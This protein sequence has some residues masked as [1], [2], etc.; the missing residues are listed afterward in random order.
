MPPLGAHMSVAGGLHKGIESALAHGC[1]CLQI[2]TKS[3]S[4]WAGPKLSDA[5]IATFKEAWKTGGKSGPLVAHDAYLTNL[6]SPDP[7]LWEKS[8]RAF[9]EQILRA[10]LLGL[11]FLVMHPGAHMGSGES[12]GVS[13]VARGLDKAVEAAGSG[14]PMILL[15][16][17]AGQGTTLGW[18][19]E[20]LRDIIGLSSHGRG[21]GICL[22]TCHAHAAGYAL[23]SPASGTNLLDEIDKVVGLEKLRVI[24]VNDSKKPA[25]S[26]A[27]RHEHLGRGTLAINA[28]GALLSD[29]RVSMKSM[30]LETPKEDEGGNPMDPENLRVLRSLVETGSVSPGRNGSNPPRGSADARQCP[31]SKPR[32]GN[33]RRN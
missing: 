23:D 17:T 5:E 29:P 16:S 7:D 24:H 9:T 2:F 32:Q 27:D 3:P 21:I 31:A 4:Q 30:I 25:G 26:R 12:A 13:R 15:E 11:D 10:R 14:P 8:I 6:A 20:H 18:R 28:L 1:D 33:K 19:M 22:D